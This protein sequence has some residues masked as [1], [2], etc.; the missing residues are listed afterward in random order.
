MRK[1]LVLLLLGPGLL[2]SAQ[3][4][5]FAKTLPVRSYSVG[6]SGSW[7]FAGN[8]VALRSIGV[9]ADDPGAMVLAATGGYGITYSLDVGAKFLYVIGGKPY[10]G[11]DLQYLL[12]EARFAY[13][14]VIGGLHYWDYFGGDLTGL[15]TWNPSRN[16][17]LSAGLDVDIDYTHD[18]D[19]KVRARVWLPV[20]V[21]LNVTDYTFIYGEFGLR[22]SEWSWGMFSLGANFIIR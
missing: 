10:F 15:F 6:F 20:N 2:A 11:A 7:Y 1:L 17:N 13:F 21:G 8:N 3:V 12:Y 19:S 5:H 16:L 9:E 4:V 14:S 18:L 22:M